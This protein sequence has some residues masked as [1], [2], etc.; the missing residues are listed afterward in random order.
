MKRDNKI[1]KLRFEPERAFGNLRRVSQR[2]F[3]IFQERLGFGNRTR[4]AQTPIAKGERLSS[5]FLLGRLTDLR[6]NFLTLRDILKKIPSVGCWREN[7]L[8][9]GYYPLKY[10]NCCRCDAFLLQLELVFTRL[11][12]MFDCLKNHMK[13]EAIS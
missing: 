5:I 6:H 9:R 4:T 7:L 3:T 8:N 2:V 13:N 12:D 11:I 10:C 1:G